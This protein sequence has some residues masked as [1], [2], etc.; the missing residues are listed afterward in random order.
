[1]HP[2]P[3]TASNPNIEN[4]LDML[5]FTG[6]ACLYGLI[7]AAQYPSFNPKKILQIKSNSLTSL[8][9]ETAQENA[10]YAGPL[11]LEQL[12]QNDFR[13][14]KWL[15]AELS[16]RPFASIMISSQPTETLTSHLAWLSDVAH[17]DGTEW[18]MRYYDPRI[19]PHW[20]AVL[21]P[22]QKSL[23]LRGIH[24]WIYLD[25]R[26]Q[27]QVIEGEDKEIPAT[28]E[29]PMCLSVQQHE[30]LMQKCLPYMLMNM[31]HDDDPSLLESI[32]RYQR[33]DYLSE[34]FLKAR[35]HQLDSMMDIKTYCMLTLMFGVNIDSDPEVKLVLKQTLQQS[36]FSQR[37]RAWTPAQWDAIS[38]GKS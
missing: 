27:W 15:L 22:E 19:L 25:V 24:R 6:T 20:L 28:P 34:Q 1:M 3:S 5:N 36:A 37:V 13:A 12:Q 14:L 29:H 21:T 18:V 38:A 17:E 33:Y 30:Q 2:S 23:A 11:F 35:E 32:P 26:G 7:D 31:L 10:I 4:L 16:Q 9:G 8:L